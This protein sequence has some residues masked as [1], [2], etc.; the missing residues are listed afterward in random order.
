MKAIIVDDE[1]Y[2]REAIYLL[3]DWKRLG[4]EEVLEAEDGLQ[5]IEKISAEQPQIV[6]TDMIMPLRNGVFLLDWL[7]SHHPHSKIIVVSGHNDFEYMR[8]TIL[9]GGLDYLLKPV[10]QRQLNAAI[11]K[12][13]LTWNRE[14]EMRISN[15]KNQAEMIEFKSEYVY[16]FLSN[17]LLDPGLF[18]S[19][20]PYI[21]D[22]LPE[23]SEAA[24]CRVGVVNFM[25]PSN[26]QAASKN[27]TRIFSALLKISHLMMAAAKCGTAFQNWHSSN[28]LV[29]LFWSKLDRP[30]DVIRQINE[31]LFQSFGFRSDFS[32]SSAFPF[33]GGI[34]N[35]Y[36]QACKILRQ[37]NLLNGKNRVHMEIP[38]YAPAR[39]TALQMKPVEDK[40]LLAI[41][42]GNQEQIQ[43][44]LE[45]WFSG[46]KQMEQLTLEQYDTWFKEYSLLKAGWLEQ[47]SGINSQDH[48]QS[49]VSPSLPLNYSGTPDFLAWHH[50]LL[51]DI[52]YLVTRFDNF[53]QQTQHTIYA[54]AQY[55]EDNYK[56]DLSLQDI[57]DQFQLSREHIS[58][59][60]KQVF[61]EGLTEFRNRIRIEK[62]KVLLL[63]PQLKV[64]TIAEMVGYKDEKYFNRIF[65]KY[66]SSTPKAFRLNAKE[67]G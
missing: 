36:L 5:A 60:F 45:E 59:K 57:A 28:E 64:D 6:I 50:G 63:N 4:I 41:R 21:T 19:K 46:I 7:Y 62:A 31:E 40:L 22:Q 9:S 17:A 32:V 20:N 26:I 53:Q 12:A 66:T 16:K 30:A 58:R 13:I 47:Y 10:K 42:S 37:R 3:A 25:L 23:I 49:Y 43:G 18:N 38:A 56:Y 51:Q 24:I 11:D 54:I 61:H 44:F 1:Q 65:K 27:P 15:R 8:Q 35:A 14:E 39:N 67:L 34:R 29:L 55:I 52:A 48:V 33:P 2:V